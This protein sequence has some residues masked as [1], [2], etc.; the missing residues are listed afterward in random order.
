[1]QR[2]VPRRGF[3]LI[4]LLVVIAIIAILAAILFPVF[5]QAREKARQIACVSNEKQILNAMMQYTQDYDEMLPRLQTGPVRW[6]G[7]V[8]STDQ[9]FG[10]E[11]ALDPYIKSGAPWGPQRPGGVWQCP[12]DSVQR[13]DCDGPPI[14]QGTGWMMSYGFTIYNPC[15]PITQFGLFAQAETC[16]GAKLDSVSLAGIG[17]PADTVGMYEF[18][19]PDA[20]YSRFRASSRSN[21]ANVADPTWP[22]FPNTLSI[23]NYC[24]DGYEW[25][26]CFGSH[27][28]LMN[29]GFMDGHVK[30]VKRTTLA[31]VVNGRWD[32]LPPNKMHWDARFH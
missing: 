1:M 23:G 14:G 3:T 30:A 16:N 12:D 21:V 32:G 4:E 7:N 2:T 8:N 20:G 25:R 11:N 31:H 27:N 15:N 26:Y 17:L 5:A 18:F 13:D 10:M 9:A 22:E 19:G 29:A 28:G 6:D 24:G